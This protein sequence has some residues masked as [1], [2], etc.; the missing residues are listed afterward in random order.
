MYKLL[1]VEDE[2][3][4]RKDLEKGTDWSKMG[5]DVI[6]AV[7][8]GI[9]ALNIIEKTS[10]EVVLTD[11]RMPDMDGIELMKI[12]STNY[13]NIRVVILSGY[14]N[15]EYARDALRYGAFEY[16]TKPLDESELEGVFKRLYDTLR[17]ENRD[18]REN[19][20]S[21]ERSI[22]EDYM[23]DLFISGLL[24]KP[25]NQ[26]FILKSIKE[27]KINMYENYI[28]VAA[29]KISNEQINDRHFISIS[30]RILKSY[31]YFIVPFDGY[32][33]IVMSKF[34]RYSM[35][36]FL[37][38]VK[39]YKLQVE[40]ELSVSI[41][42]ECILSIGISK[43]NTTFK[44]VSMAWKEAVTAFNYIFYKGKGNIIQYNEINLKMNLKVLDI[45]VNK[46]IEDLAEAFLEKN[47]INMRVIMEQI[48]RNFDSMKIPDIIYVKLK[49]MEIFLALG[50]RMHERDMDNEIIIG[51]DLIYSEIFSKE[52]LKELKFWFINKLD[53]VVQELEYKRSNLSEDGLVEKIKK[54]INENI[55]K[56]VSLN[57]LAEEVHVTQNYISTIF[58][59]ETGIILTNY[60][61][62]LKIQKA[63]EYL[64]SSRLRIQDISEMLG[65]SDYR[66]FCTLFRK[67]TGVTPLEYRSQMLLRK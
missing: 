61:T 48:F 57:K 8:N 13:P 53:E 41:K 44:G 6:G 60:I 10:P 18:K 40:N 51:K 62:N 21:V 11:I 66:Y 25:L 34:S 42:K 2:D 16:L 9:E 5:F 63:K 20:K 33:S 1:I 32:F 39:Q 29:V 36:D 38:D 22:D 52:S 67:E 28:C 37:N 46:A 14:N 47:T 65:Y 24:T 56:K 58:K 49:I 15:F 54:Y 64:Q 45:E 31:G 23:T 17:K 55:D 7:M 4:L 19:L 50:I 59:K 3:I 30:K 26:E 12:L 35:Q 43:V 27:L